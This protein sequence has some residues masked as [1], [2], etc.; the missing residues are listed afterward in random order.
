MFVGTSL[1]YLIIYYSFSGINVSLFAYVLAHVAFL[2]FMVV[3]KTFRIKIIQEIRIKNFFSKI[4]KVTILLYILVFFLYLRIANRH[5]VMIDPDSLTNYNWIRVNLI[6]NEINYF[7]GLTLLY[8]KSIEI[9]DPFGNINFFSVAASFVILVLTNLVLR[10][11]FNYKTVVLFNILLLLPIFSIA[12]FIRIGLN[13]TS[14]M[15][16]FNMSLLVLLI[17][18]YK[19]KLGNKESL[20][21]LYTI[22]IGGYLISPNVTLM[23]IPPFLWVWIFI[24]FYKEHFLRKFFYVL[25]SISIISL[26]SFLYYRQSINF[27][28]RLIKNNEQDFIVSTD[29]IV[30][31]DFI[32]SYIKL[33]IRIFSIKLPY[34]NPLESPLALFSYL[35]FP[36]LLIIFIY[37]ARKKRPEIMITSWL[38]FYF[39]LSTNFGFG[40]ASFLNGRLAYFLVFNV[41][42]LVSILSISM[43]D[44]F[45]KRNS[46]FKPVSYLSVVLLCIS[47]FFFTPSPW[48]SRSEQ[49]LFDF[50][51]IYNNLPSSL[52]IYSQFNEIKLLGKGLDVKSIDLSNFNSGE[53]FR[54]DVIALNVSYSIP[55]IWRYLP[56]EITD[57]TWYQDITGDNHMKYYNQEILDRKVLNDRI[58]KQASSRNFQVF[59]MISNDYIILVNNNL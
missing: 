11:Q 25:N 6:E 52:S 8:Q 5:I 3:D 4:K 15:L 53:V 41:L 48:S 34:R 9:I 33:F 30:S 21:Y 27:W 12:L 42:L 31:T 59:K 19:E 24:N 7:P 35:L 44:H 46:L 20:F 13:T 37:G 54:S 43:F 39:L 1:F 14:L 16:L 45:S 32:V 28:F 10:S 23:L 40:E 2:L 26:G 49:I 38:S 47:I 55:P 22:L 58:L 36:T 50:K 29:S 17:G 51:K 18:N 57:I 56:K